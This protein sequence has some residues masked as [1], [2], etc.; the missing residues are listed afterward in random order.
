[1]G[2]YTSVIIGKDSELQ[3]KS[4]VDDCETYR[5]GD[6]VNWKIWPDQP[7][8]GKLL[9]GVY[10]AVLVGN[11]TEIQYSV[12]IDNHRV[13]YAG[14]ADV[15]VNTE[16]IVPYQRGWWSESAWL[17]KDQEDAEQRL[18]IAKEEVESLRKE[19]AFLSTL[20]GLDDS[21][22]ADRR[23][24]FYNGRLQDALVS[25]L[26]EITSRPSL[27]RQLLMVTPAKSKKTYTRSR[28]KKMR[29]RPRNKKRR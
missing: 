1:M 20:E 28:S 26:I 14:R 19:I 8:I 25:G 11:K 10:E 4:D 16:K 9:D 5:I 18:R 29:T 23:K 6:V 7:G 21:E 13:I 15:F 17:K 3:F 22:I 24:K 12:V 27:T 2:M